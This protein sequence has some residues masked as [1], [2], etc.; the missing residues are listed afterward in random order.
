M[1]DSRIVEGLLVLVPDAQIGLLSE[2]YIT[3]LPSL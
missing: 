3:K 1:D 2:V